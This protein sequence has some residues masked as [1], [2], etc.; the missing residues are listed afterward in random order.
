MRVKAMLLLSGLAGTLSL[1]AV[2]PQASAAPGTTAPLADRAGSAGTVPAGT[3]PITN[4]HEFVVDAAHGHLF[5]TQGYGG[6][7]NFTKHN[8]ITVTN[9]SGK[10]V[11]TIGGQDNVQGIA[12]SPDGST[13]YAADEGDDAVS[14]ISTTTLQETARYPLGTGNAPYGVAVQSGKVWVGYQGPAGAFIGE[15][16][17]VLPATFTPQAMSSFFSV[18]LTSR[19]IRPTAARCWPP[20]ATTRS[21]GRRSAAT[22]SRPRRLPYTS[23]RPPRAAAAEWS[24]TPSS[25]VARTSSLLARGPRIPASRRPPRRSS[26]TARPSC[27]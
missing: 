3:L 24:A 26:T 13:L 16:D 22:T 27:R 6:I 12:L 4:F 11:A 10:L 2:Q 8:A 9:L 20:T 21:T 5:F 1:T 18:G 17:P 25:L 14:A 23:R 15:I 7:D 19:A